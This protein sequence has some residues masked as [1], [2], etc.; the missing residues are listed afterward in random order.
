VLTSV[1][2]DLV[3]DAVIVA[4]LTKFADHTGA[5]AAAGATVSR[6]SAPEHADQLRLPAGSIAA[7]LK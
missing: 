5:V 2:V 1:A 4:L 3:Q 6:I 7:T